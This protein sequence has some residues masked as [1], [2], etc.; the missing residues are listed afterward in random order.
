MEGM[1][2]SLLLDIIDT[3]DNETTYYDDN[4]SFDNG[5]H[6]MIRLSQKKK[7]KFCVDF[8]LNYTFGFLPNKEG[9]MISSYVFPSHKNYIYRCWELGL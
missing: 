4:I 3:M 8:F 7:I 5:T 9:N 6:G 1:L 2:R